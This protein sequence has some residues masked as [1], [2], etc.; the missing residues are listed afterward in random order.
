MKKKII[1]TAICF[2]AMMLAG[3]SN[4]FMD[5][6][7]F[8][9]SRSIFPQNEEDKL[10]F[11]GRDFWDPKVS[12]KNKYKN[13]DPKQ[14]PKFPGSTGAFVFTTD[15]WHLF[16]FI[17]LSLLQLSIALTLIVIWDIPYRWILLAFLP[18]KFAFSGGF[19]LF[20]HHL[21]KNKKPILK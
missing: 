13:K 11:K 21:L 10:L 19:V 18:F 7:Q 15:G 3:V 16:Q 17:M 2:A 20:F 1:I 12:W 5:K 8:H 14:G 9:Y 4:G 6:I